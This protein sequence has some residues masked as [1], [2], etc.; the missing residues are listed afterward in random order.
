MRLFW[1]LYIKHVLIKQNNLSACFFANQ[2]S[3]FLKCTLRLVWVYRMNFSKLL[4]CRL[5]WVCQ[6][7]FWKPLEHR[8]VRVYHL[9]FSMLFNCRLVWVYHMNFSKLLERT[10]DSREFTTWTSQNC[11]NADSCELTTWTCQN[12]GNINVKSNRF[13]EMILWPIPDQCWSKLLSFMRWCFHSKQSYSKSPTAKK[14]DPTTHLI[15]MPF[16][17]KYNVTFSNIL[18]W[19]R[20]SYK[21]PWGL[22]WLD[23]QYI[24]NKYT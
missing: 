19:Q 15:Y 1:I 9:N 8:L 5:V 21:R 22:I 10:V 12:L 18:S 23:I 4:E 17:L 7:N 16:P 14:K 3:Q 2:L 20:P 11:R 6:M 24:N 13:N